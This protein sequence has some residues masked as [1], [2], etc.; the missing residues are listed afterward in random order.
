M[1]LKWFFSH[2]KENQVKV[3]VWATYIAKKAIFETSVSR[4]QC[5]PII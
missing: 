4:T 1:S 5:A 2:S 3:D